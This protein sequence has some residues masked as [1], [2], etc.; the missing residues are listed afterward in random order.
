MESRK[1]NRNALRSKRLIREAFTDLLREK[2]FSKITVT[3]IVTRAGINRST[4]Y[5]HY[6]DV[7]G[8][9]ESFEDDAVAK[10]LGI[11]DDFEF[12]DFFADPLPLLS[13]INDH[14]EEG[15]G[16]YRAMLAEV[17]SGSVFRRLRSAFTERMAT[18]EGIPRQVRESYAFK[19]RV[20]FF[21]SGVLGLY[22]EWLLGGGSVPL[23]EIS[24][25]LARVIS[26][27]SADMLASAGQTG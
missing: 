9:V 15:A 16:F 11:L 22:E 13:R 27:S 3:D 23:D 19:V 26:E 14:V 10:M 24:R 6:P 21:A 1:E 25:E 4:F 17:G 5:A 18:D 12:G 8:L 2:E 7:R 20:G